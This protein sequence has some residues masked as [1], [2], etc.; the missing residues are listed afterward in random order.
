MD[1]DRY[2]GVTAQLYF[3]GGA[4]GRRTMN[5]DSRACWLPAAAGLLAF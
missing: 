4:G 3:G 2:E 5:N 1:Q